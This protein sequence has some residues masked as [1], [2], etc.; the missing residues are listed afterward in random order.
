MPSQVL[1]PKE[2][3]VNARRHSLLFEVEY[4]YWPYGTLVMHE[5]PVGPTPAATSADHQQVMSTDLADHR[6]QV[7]TGW[8]QG[9]AGGNET[10]EFSPI[11]VFKSHLHR[12][13]TRVFPGSAAA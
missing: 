12:S 13:D 5:L 2:W 10:W 7:S 1:Q 8:P 3:L 9:P 4:S 6:Y 11:C